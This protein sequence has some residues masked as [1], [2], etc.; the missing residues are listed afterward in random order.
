MP[1]GQLSQACRR[2]RRRPPGSCRAPVNHTFLRRCRRR[3][4]ANQDQFPSGPTRRTARRP[5]FQSPRGAALPIYRGST[6]S[7]GRHRLRSAGSPASFAPNGTTRPPRT[8][9]ARPASCSCPV[10][11]NSPGSSPGRRRAPTCPPGAG[12]SPCPRA[13]STRRAAPGSRTRRP[14]R[15]PGPASCSRSPR[16][17]PPA[18]CPSATDPG[19]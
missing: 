6:P 16:S 10:R 7:C 11:R 15:G 1:R 12:C 14:P 2:S 18:S 9:G 3:N 4:L 5:Y 13:P 17:S 19:P 8:S